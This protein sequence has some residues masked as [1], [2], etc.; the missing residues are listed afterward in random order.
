M[1]LFK[2]FSD[3]N[4]YKE[5]YFEDQ[6]EMNVTFPNGTDHKHELPFFQSF[7]L[8]SAQEVYETARVPKKYFTKDSEDITIRFIKNNFLG[9][10]PIY[11]KSQKDLWI[12]KI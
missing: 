8:N 11:Y 12:V 10:M 7:I 6:I 1:K 9:T 2:E 3:L 4:K 5:I